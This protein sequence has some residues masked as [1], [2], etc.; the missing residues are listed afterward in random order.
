MKPFFGSKRIYFIV[1]F[2]ILFSILNISCGDNYGFGPEY[3]SAKIKQKIG[4]FLMC[5]ATHEADLHNFTWN[6]GY[7]YEAPN[8][9]SFDIGSGTYYN[10]DWEKNE[11]LVNFYKWTILATGNDQNS[12]KL[13]IGQLNSNSWKDYAI[14]PKDIEANEL[15]KSKNIN[16]DLDQLPSK[17]IIKNV[18]TDGKV[19]VIYKYAKK[20]HFWFR[21]GKMLITYQVDSTI[22]SPVM[23]DVSKF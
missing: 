16:S 1:L 23:T 19:L 11:Q 22:G 17:T 4:G 21:D 7:I 9:E 20:N 15:W 14:T 10:R 2:S 8:S 12:E 3:H 13:I 18:R 6:V 5:Q